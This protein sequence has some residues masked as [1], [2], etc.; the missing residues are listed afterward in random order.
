[1]PKTCVKNKVCEKEVEQ[2]FREKLTI[3]HFEEQYQA[4]YTEFIMKNFK[5]E[6]VDDIFT[7]IIKLDAS[8]DWK[9]AAIDKA[10]M[11]FL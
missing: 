8:S 4:S 11:F 6:M 5:Y 1:M 7:P 2:Y 9:Q 10:K 3:F